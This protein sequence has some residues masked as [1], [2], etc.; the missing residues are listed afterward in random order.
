MLLISYRRIFC[1]TLYVS[2]LL[3]HFLYFLCF[4]YHIRLLSTMEISLRDISKAVK[5]MIVM[6]SDLD[7]M[8]TAFLNNQVCLVFII[9][10]LLAYVFVSVRVYVRLCKYRSQEEV[11]V[12]I[13]L[14]KSDSL[15]FSLPPFLTHSLTLTLIHALTFASLIPASS[16]SCSS[17]SS[18]KLSTCSSFH[19][20]HL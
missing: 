17:S 11:F 14:Y 20:L 12:S 4:Q 5:G 3:Q 1:V 18:S 15:T 10:S 2:S 16:S 9:N 7:S 6:S 19:F 13:S 8:H